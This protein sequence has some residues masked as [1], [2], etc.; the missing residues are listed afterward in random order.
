MGTHITARLPL[1]VEQK[2]TEYCAKRGVK[3]SEAVLRALDQYLDNEGGGANAVLARRRSHSC[4]G[5]QGNTGGQRASARAQG[6][7]WTALSLTPARSSRS[8]IAPTVITRLP[9]NGSAGTAVCCLPLKQSSRKPPTF[10]RRAGRI[11]A[12]PCSGSIARGRR[13]CCRW[14]RFRATLRLTIS[15]GATRSCRAITPTRRL[16]SSLNAA[17]LP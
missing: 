6:V 13:S 1:R 16:S 3:R 9:W 7:P 11:K 4:G 15:S 2:L 8:S 10:W 12:P 5:H 14:S 17:G